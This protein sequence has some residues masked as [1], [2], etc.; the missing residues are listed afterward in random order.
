ML[1][2]QGNL[3]PLLQGRSYADIVWINPEGFQLND[4]Q[5]NAENVAY[6]INYISGISGNKNVSLIGWSQ[7][8]ESMQW[9]LK[10]W[11]STRK[12]VTDQIAVSAVSR[13][14]SNYA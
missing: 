5:T 2:R 13:V 8:S 4:A 1:H 11:P 9:A 3:I 6:T 10:Y 14:L 7:G 12:I